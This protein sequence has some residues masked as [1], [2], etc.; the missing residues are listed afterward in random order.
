VI[1][2]IARGNLEEVNR[3]KAESKSPPA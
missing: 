2:R 1:E 3:I